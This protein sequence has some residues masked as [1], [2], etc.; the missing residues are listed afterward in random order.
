MK[1][2]QSVV[3][4]VFD[5]KRKRRVSQRIIVTIDLQAAAQK[6]AA[7]ALRSESRR[8]RTPD[9]VVSALAG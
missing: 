4:D 6:L 3:V 2:T 9:G 1:Y 5:K 8:A 7:K